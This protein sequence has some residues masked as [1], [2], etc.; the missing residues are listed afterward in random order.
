[1][2]NMHDNFQASSSTGM[3][4][5]GGD[6]RKD[7]QETSRH[8]WR[9]PFTKILTP[10]YVNPNKSSDGSGNFYWLG[11]GRVGSAIN[12]LGWN[13]ENFSLKCQIFQFFS[14]RVK[15]NLLGSGQKVP[16]SKAGRPLIYCRSKVSSGRVRTHL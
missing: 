5:G 9:D 1:V 15:K 11:S 7:E 13:L 8:F 4:G 6:R 12:G 2:G 3:Q 16:G 10:P 14:L